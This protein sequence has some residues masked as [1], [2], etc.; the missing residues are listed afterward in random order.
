MRT[1]LQ[2]LALLNRDAPDVQM[3]VAGRGDTV[4]ALKSYAHALNVEH[5]VVFRGLVSH[6]DLVQLFHGATAL[7]F[8]SLVEGF[9]LPVLEAMAAG[10][11]VIASDCPTLAE[12]AG[13]A[14]L[15]CNPRKPEEFAAAMVRVLRDRKLQADLRNRG[16]QRAALFSWDR[17]AAHT[18]AVYQKLL[19]PVGNGRAVTTPTSHRHGPHLS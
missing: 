16:T 12:I 2:A 13:A 19:D 18:L 1:A 3:V 10:C 4:A 9:G 8:P 15:F 14:A 17:S 11:P 5:R 7:V 6:V